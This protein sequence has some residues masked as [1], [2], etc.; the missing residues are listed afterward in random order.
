MVR[1]ALLARDDNRTASELTAA[2][3]RLLRELLDIAARAF[4]GACRAEDAQITAADYAC[5][6]ASERKRS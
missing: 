5:Y 2:E 6:V 1:Y 4:T 3:E